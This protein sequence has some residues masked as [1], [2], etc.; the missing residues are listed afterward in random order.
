MS[1][2]GA[3]RGLSVLRATRRGHESRDCTAAEGEHFAK[4]ECGALDEQCFYVRISLFIHTI[5]KYIYICI[6]I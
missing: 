5:Y 1:P 3:F 4:G 2:K 6:Y